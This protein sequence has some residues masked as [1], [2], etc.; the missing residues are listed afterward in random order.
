MRADSS[1][2]SSTERSRRKSAG[3]KSPRLEDDNVP[4]HQLPALHPLAFALPQHLGVGGGK[5]FQGLDGFVRPALLHGA[6]D[7]VDTPQWPK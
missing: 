4:G 2:F 5:L 7:G 3:T 1:V 6:D